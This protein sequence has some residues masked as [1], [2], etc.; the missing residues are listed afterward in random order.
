MTRTGWF[1]CSYARINALHEAAVLSFRGN[2]CEIPTDCP[3]RERA[4]WTGD[5]QLS[6]PTAAFLYNVAGFTTRW[7]RDL[8]AEQRA[9]GMVSNIVP[10]PHPP[11][12]GSIA[13]FMLGSAGWGDAAVHVPYQQWQSSGDTDILARQYDSMR[14]W[15]GFAL[16]RA[17]EGRH[18]ARAAARPEPAAHER[19]GP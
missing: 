4:G 19:Y 10:D 9:D 7:L 14:A 11:A 15:V 13:S 12:P 18:P 1:R 16:K 5:W 3:T 8:T 2:A 17:A 6:F